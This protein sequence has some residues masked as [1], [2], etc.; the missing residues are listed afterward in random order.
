MAS[1]GVRESRKDLDHRAWFAFRLRP[2]SVS[3]RVG[4]HRRRRGPGAGRKR[5][6]FPGAQEIA[7]VSLADCGRPDFNRARLVDL[8]QLSPTLCR[9][10]AL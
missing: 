8:V 6:I 7:L 3:P 2:R 4:N 1:S 9:E 10:A 5:L